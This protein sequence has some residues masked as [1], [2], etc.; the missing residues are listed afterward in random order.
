MACFDFLKFISLICA[1]CSFFSE[2]F[3]HEHVLDVHDVNPNLFADST[4]K[5][6]PATWLQV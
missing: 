5:S 3:I 6:K 1:G 2:G 4:R